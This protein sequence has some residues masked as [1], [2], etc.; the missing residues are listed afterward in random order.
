VGRKT[1][2]VR[3]EYLEAVAS[4]I[5]SATHLLKEGLDLAGQPP[6]EIL[7]DLAK[8]LKQIAEKGKIT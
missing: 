2:R 3:P 5:E 8:K 4:L 1:I 7:M 6:D